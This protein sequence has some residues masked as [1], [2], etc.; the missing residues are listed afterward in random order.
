MISFEQIDDVI[1]GYFQISS[2]EL[3]YKTRKKEVIEARQYSH[4]F[5]IKLTKFDY[6]N[7]GKYFGNLTASTISYSLKTITRLIEVDNHAREIIDELKELF[8]V[9]I[10]GNK[11]RLE[12]QINLN[13]ANT[14]ISLIDELSLIES[15][16]LLNNIT[17]KIL[18]KYDKSI[19]HTKLPVTS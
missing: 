17:Q 14:V 18:D 4:Y 7:I 15:V 11:K 10:E 3:H 8:D 1:C 16:R 19:N 5:A 13:K 12:H 9:I 2:E 6:I